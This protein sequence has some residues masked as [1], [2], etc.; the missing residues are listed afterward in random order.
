MSFAGSSQSS[1]LSCQPCPSVRDSPIPSQPHAYAGDDINLHSSNRYSL[2]VSEQKA[3]QIQ[4]VEN[5]D[6]L[7]ALQTLDLSYNRIQSLSGLQ[8]LDYLGVI[9]LEGNL[10]PTPP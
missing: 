3:N 10:V 8:N 4:R 6:S 5:M 2:C 7:R 1:V 9:N